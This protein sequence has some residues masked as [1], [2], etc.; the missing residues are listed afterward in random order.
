MD[1]DMDINDIENPRT[2]TELLT[3]SCQEMQTGN[4]KLKHDWITLFAELEMK[5]DDT[6]RPYDHIWDMYYDEFDDA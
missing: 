4:L 2:P 1:T 3:E 6:F 5:R